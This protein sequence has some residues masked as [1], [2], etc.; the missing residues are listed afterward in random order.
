MKA[1]VTIYDIAEALNLSPSTV[2][3]AL[4]DNPRIKLKTRQ[5]VQEYAASKG[6]R[7]N[8][9]A[10]NLRRSKTNI[11]GLM[12]HEINSHFI[13]DVIAG[14]EEITAA[15]G[16]DL[17]IA[18]SSEKKEKEIANAHNLFQKRVDAIIASLSFETDDLSHFRLFTDKNIPI[19]FFDR[20][21][22]SIEA[23]QVVIDNK[24]AGFAATEHLIQQGCKHI[25]HI[26][27]NQQRNVYA[28]RLAGYKAALKKYGIPF[29][30]QYVL[31][32][33][34]K[35]RSE[36][37]EAA[38]EILAMQPRPDGIFISNDNYAALC[39]KALQNEQVRIPE[40]I[41]IIGFN[42]DVVSRIISPELSTIHYPGKEI[43]RLAAQA[44]IDKLTNHTPNALQK[45]N[46]KWELLVRQSSRKNPA[47]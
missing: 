4:N 3:R 9:F 34:F 25:V 41:A 18:L 13:T 43:G 35:S 24:K 28:A 27:A 31:I 1:E 10:S 5:R 21:D 32:K 42:N 17:L 37:E 23:L 39:I 6:F 47:V 7:L 46:A 26:T 8:T 20:V 16:Y 15:S 36:G 11:I 40:D 22:D 19:A 38:K 2:S 44:V 12:V 30:K 29:E 33:D 45:I 14:I